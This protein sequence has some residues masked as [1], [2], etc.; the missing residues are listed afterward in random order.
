MRLGCPR[1][2]TVFAKSKAK[3]RANAPAS[4]GV[5]RFAGN[6]PPS[7]TEYRAARRNAGYGVWHGFGGAFLLSGWC[8]PSSYEA[9]TR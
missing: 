1:I 9:V 4:G 3:N 8:V 2:V 7:C 5:A 6:T